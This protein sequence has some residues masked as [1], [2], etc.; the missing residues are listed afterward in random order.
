MA[1][2]TCY[3]KG[4]AADVVTQTQV[5]TRLDKEDNKTQLQGI[6]N[7]CTTNHTVEKV[8]NRMN[9]NLQTKSID[10]ARNA[11][12]ALFSGLWCGC[13]QHWVYNIFY[14]CLI[15]STTVYGSMAKVLVDNFMYVPGIYFPVYYTFK[16]LFLSDM[17]ISDG[18]KSY[19]NEK[20]TV[21]PAY[22][23]VC[24]PAVFIIFHFVPMEF[25][26]ASIA[27]LGFVWLCV[28][29][30]LSPMTEN[31]DNYKTNQVSPIESHTQTI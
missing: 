19:W 16:S 13:A 30:F 8:S 20:W 26:I 12:F 17:Q 7:T 22:W 3:T 4:S 23:K 11:R 27:G 6:Q 25:R 29:S 1:F 31:K 21:L 9:P 14:P 15:P 5:E 24:L 10:C 18:I 2:L 28:L